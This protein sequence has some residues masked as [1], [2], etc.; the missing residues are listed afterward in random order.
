MTGQPLERRPFGKTGLLV[1]VLGFGAAPAAYLSAEADTTAKLLEAIL[2][3]GLNLLDTASSYPGSEAFIG[4]H[5]AHRRN[6][7][8]LVSKCGP[9]VSGVQGDAWSARLIGQTVDQ[10]LRLLRTDRLDVMLL[11]SCDL[12]TLHL[13]EAVPALVKA[14]QAG[15]VRF[16]GYSGDNEAAAYAATLP[17][18]A[19]IETSISIADQRNIDLVLPGAIER[20]L[21][22]IAKRPIANAAWKKSADQRGLYRSYSQTYSKRLTAMKLDPANLGIAGPANVAWPELAL[23]FT[24]SQPGVHTLVVGTTNPANA[25]ANLAAAAKGPLPDKTVARIRDAFKKADPAG[26]W[27]GEQ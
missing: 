21:G 22:V 20:H 14:R 1:S 18:L 10:S 8:I 25:M 12:A 9:R 27:L 4:K 16:A 15:K 2:D 13:E 6:D 3:R 17:D 7:F 24:L 23:R 19:V 26:K 11:H 5:L